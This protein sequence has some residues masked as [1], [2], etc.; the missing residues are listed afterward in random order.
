[1]P[2]TRTPAQRAKDDSEAEV[3]GR[4]PV[5]GR[6]GEPL[7]RGAGSA[8]AAQSPAAKAHFHA[9]AAHAQVDEVLA[10]AKQLTDAAAK[11]GLASK[12]A[13]D[14]AQACK[15][16]PAPAPAVDAAEQKSKTAAADAAEAEARQRQADEADRAAKQSMARDPA[17]RT[18]R[19][20]PGS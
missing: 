14:A 3:F 2:D 7:E 19:V 8:Y 16:A 11:L 9:V 18:P 17:Q 12:A 6:D 5:R 15:V 1:M 20:N 13:V 10:L 4:D